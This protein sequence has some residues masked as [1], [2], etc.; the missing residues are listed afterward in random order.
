MNAETCTRLGSVEDGRPAPPLTQ[1]Y[2]EALHTGESY[3][4]VL[5]NIKNFRYYNTAYGNAGGDE[6]LALVLRQ[7]RGLLGEGEYADHLYAD[8]FAGL[9]KYE[10][11]HDLVYVRLFDMIDKLYRIDDPRVYRDIFYSIGIYA[12]SDPDVPFADALNLANLCRKESTLTNRSSCLEL[13]DMSYYQRYMDR[14]K[15]ESDTADAYKNYEFVAY[16]Q[17]KVELSTGRVVG[18]ESLLRWFDK[19]G[20]PIPLN[21]FLPILNQNTYIILIDIDLFDQTCSWL[22]QRIR[23]GKSV[24]PISF[25]LSQSA[26]YDP[27]LVTMYTDV[28]ERYDLPKKLIEIELMESISLSDTDRMKEIIT[29]FRDYGF[30]CSLDDFG[31][32]YSSFNVLLNAQLDIVKMDRQ[33][34]LNNMN[35]DSR[36]VIKTVVDLLHSLNVKVVAEG[37]ELQEHIDWLRDCGCDF[38]QG[39]YYYKPMSV[40]DF[41]ALLDAQTARENGGNQ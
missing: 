38:V 33:F 31:N 37:V 4:L 19:N 36:L 16:L 3:A 20:R 32:G 26:F 40:K 8:N 28:F 35:G 30:T 27:S 23:D 10:N 29:A 17:P 12:M 14:M 21:K 15:L 13:Y 11:T 34:F 25:N 39:Y 9:L 41:A 5:F 7:L 18:A 22:A 24:V 2:L 1:R 6:I